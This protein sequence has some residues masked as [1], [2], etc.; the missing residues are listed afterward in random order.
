MIHYIVGRNLGHLNR[1]VANIS[2]FNRISK[3]SVKVY[4]FNNKHYWLKSNLPNLKIRP[5]DKRK[6]TKKLLKADLV[7][8]D[9]REEVQKLKEMREQKGPIIGGIYHSDLS[10]SGKDTDWT[11]KF[12]RQIHEISQKTTDIF[13][14]INLTQP[15]EIPKLS[16][17]Y[18]PIPLIAREIKMQPSKVKERLGIPKNEPFI[19]VQMGGGIGKYRYKFM[20]QWYNI[21]NQLQIPYHIVVANQLGGV[22]FKF[23]NHII[24]A[25][26]FENGRELVNAASTVIS[27]P[28]MG[29]LMDCISTGTPLIALPADTKEREVKNMMLR[30]LIGNEMCLATNKFSAKELAKRTEEVLKNKS[31][32]KKVFEKVPQNGSEVIAK[33]IK[34][35][36]GH[37]LTEL[38]DIYKKI[39]K[40]TPFKEK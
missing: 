18:V 40:F 9:W 26:L 12:K 38:P 33:S 31:H 37:S 24:Q 28:G 14:H 3:E 29:I 30:D 15:K 1:C 4:V 6:L 21:V 16:T 7:I 36:S 17:Q 13:F 32:Y 22:D 35:L 39:L 10:V 5:F 20:E 27:K 25:P 2:K 11:R 34:L 19:L 23:K 8:H